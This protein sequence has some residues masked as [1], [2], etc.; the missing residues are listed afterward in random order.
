M[1]TLRRDPRFLFFAAGAALALIIS[2]PNT[3][4]IAAP[5]HGATTWYGVALTIA[6]VVLLEAGAV[7]AAIA[8]VR[9]LCWSL[10]AL[11]FVANCAIGSVYLERADLAA[12]PSLES[13]RASGYG[14]M[15]VLGYAAIVP[16]LLYTF[17]EYAIARAGELL[18]VTPD[19]TPEDRLVGIL[20]AF[21]ARLPAP[22][23]AL[24]EQATYA[25]PMPVV[26]AGTQV[27]VTPAVP[28]RLYACPAC[29]QSLTQGQY[30]AA[31]RHGKC[32]QC[33]GT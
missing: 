10:L 14:W 25:R 11:T 6:L 4:Q 19:A 23:P 13:W 32:R 7:G 29:G 1:Q 9:W 33:P 21:A 30:G 12:L 27:S 17:L 2:A 28:A 3:Y 5:L 26:D 15:L 31:K 20:D 8:G 24:P 18:S 16:V 22:A